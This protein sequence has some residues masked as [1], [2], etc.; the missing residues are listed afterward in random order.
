MNRKTLLDEI[1]NLKERRAVLETECGVT[2]HNVHTFSRK[3]VHQMEED[4]QKMN[5]CIALDIV[6]S[7]IE[8]DESLFRQEA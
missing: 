5:A 8:K 3:E 7:M 1:I 6:N 4:T 2:E